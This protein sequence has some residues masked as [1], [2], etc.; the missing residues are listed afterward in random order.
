MHVH[1]PMYSD[2]WAYTNKKVTIPIS[3]YHQGDRKNFEIV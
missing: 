1:T 3:V 2:I